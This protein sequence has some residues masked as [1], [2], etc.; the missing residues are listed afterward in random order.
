MATAWQEAGC[1][2]RCTGG[3]HLNCLAEC[4]AVP[5]SEEKKA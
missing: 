2:L 3:P 4:G 1:G 5:I